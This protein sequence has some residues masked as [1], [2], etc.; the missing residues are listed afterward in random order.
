MTADLQEKKVAIEA[1]K[2]QI[3]VLNW[4]VILVIYALLLLVIRFLYSILEY[5][6]TLSVVIILTI[7]TG[8]V[9]TGLYLANSASKKAIRKIE[10]YSNK[11]HNLL[12]T[13]RDIRDIIYGDTLLDNIMTSSL[14]ITKADAGSILLAEGDWLVF[15]IVKGIESKKLLGLSVPRS[16]GIAGWVVDNGSIV[17]VNDVRNDNRFNPEVDNITGH[18]T[19]SLL[20]VP[21]KLS[22]GVIGVLELVN[23]KDGTFT[24]ED[25]ELISYFADQAAISIAR[26]KFYEDQKNYEI[27]L[28]GILLDAMDNIVPEKRGHS[29]RVAKYGLLMANA[30]NMPENEKEKLYRASLLHDIGFIKI[31]LNVSSKEE[32]KSHSRLGYELLRPISF[33]TDETHPKLGYEMLRPISFYADISSIILY[34]HERYDG[35]GYPSGLKGEAIPQ[36]SRVIAIAE[37]FDAMVSRDS[38]KSTGKMIAEDVKPSICGFKDAIEELKKNAGTQ[39]DPE[40]V[41]VFVNNIDESSVEEA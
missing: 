3:K 2:R 14:N 39:F 32:Y 22:S 26:A 15:K 36:E 20:C 8:L 29:K 37:A 23:K 28:T 17:R 11:L 40:L 25:E 27:H 9:T 7:L 35:K 31:P 38:Y 21:L 30:I 10:E 16:R 6:P 12:A 33:Y 13:T 4:V 24:D 1:I 18:K 5:I 41:E 19:I 34:H